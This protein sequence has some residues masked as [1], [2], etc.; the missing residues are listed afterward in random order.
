LHSRCS[1][2]DQGDV[3]L[4]KLHGVQTSSVAAVAT[5]SRAAAIKRRGPRGARPTSE[6]DLDGVLG[7][8]EEDDELVNEEEENRDE[9]SSDEKLSPGIDAHVL[10]VHV[11]STFYS[12]VSAHYGLIEA[13]RL[14][15]GAHEKADNERWRDRECDRRFPCRDIGPGYI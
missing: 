2:R 12:I 11:D 6:A 9:K 4:L 13:G 10:D 7:L 14:T 8:R 1:L 5:L 3:S 15:G